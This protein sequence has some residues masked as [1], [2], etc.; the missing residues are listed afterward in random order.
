M[1]L[2]ADKPIVPQLMT[3]VH[4]G[5][6]E[7][8]GREA[9]TQYEHAMQTALLAEKSGASSALITASLFHD[10][11]YMLSMAGEKPVE[12]G[13]DTMHERIAEKYLRRWFGPDVTV[14]IGLH[15]LAK[16]YLCAVNP[17][18]HA[19]LSP[20]SIASMKVQGGVMSQKEASTFLLMPYAEDAVSLRIW[21]DLAKAPDL[22]LPAVEHFRP[23]IEAALTR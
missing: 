10:L 21:D 20:A 7:A 14:P 12:W 9:V 5:G 3:L 8:Y 17:D 2:A 16:R 11:G 23:H 1:R 4:E 19:S 13:I 22:P 18:Y 6:Q 15:V